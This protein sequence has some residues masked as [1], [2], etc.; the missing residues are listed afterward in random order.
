MMPISLRI[1]CYTIINEFD[2]N[3][4]IKKDKMNKFIWEM[5]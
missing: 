4:Y 1:L 5:L 3:K 2:K